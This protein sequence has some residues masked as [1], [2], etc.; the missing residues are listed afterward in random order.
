MPLLNRDDYE[1]VRQ[2]LVAQV[3]EE[4]KRSNNREE[5]CVSTNAELSLDFGISETVVKKYL[6]DLSNSDRNYRTSVLQSESKPEGFN[7]KRSLQRLRDDLIKR[8]GEFGG[9]V[10]IPLRMAIKQSMGLALKPYE[11]PVYLDNMYLFLLGMQ[12][13][14]CSA[15]RDCFE[16]VYDNVQDRKIIGGMIH[17]LFGEFP[18]DRAHPSKYIPHRRKLQFFS[19]HVGYI[20]MALT[21]DNSYPPYELLT[22]DE[23][24]QSYLQGFLY[25]GAKVSSKKVVSSEE[26]SLRPR[27]DVRGMYKLDLMK[28]VQRLVGNLGV[29]ARG[30]SRGFAVYQIESLRRIIN[31]NLLCK[32][33]EEK[34]EG[35]LNCL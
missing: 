20:G 9:N 8:I 12:Q 24:I 18:K 17:K 19:G 2:K 31:L 22:S 7:K 1:E 35:M 14:T 13:E 27:V 28:G 3:I 23:R 16:I 4:I 30:N 11:L 15:I 21:G 29:N 6:R 33:Q 34:L 25:R 5:G 10:R 32:P 26:T